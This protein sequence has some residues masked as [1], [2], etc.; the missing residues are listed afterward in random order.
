MRNIV[1]AIISILSF[2]SSAQFT[3]CGH[4]TMNGEKVAGAHVKLLD[5]QDAVLTNKQGGFCFTNVTSGKQIIYAEFENE[6]SILLPVLVNENRSDIHLEIIPSTELEGV[7]IIG[8]S[9]VDRRKEHSIKTEV[10][11]LEAHQLSSVSVEQLMDRTAGVKVR[12]SSGLGADSDV[13]IGG[14]NGKSVK[15]LVDGIPINYLGTSMSV[16]KMPTNMAGYIEVYKG[17]LPTEIGIDAL[18]AAVNIVTKQANKTNS[19]VSYQIGSFNT[20]RL[21]ANVFI[22]NSEKISF[23]ISAFANYSDNNFKIK[24]LPYDNLETG[25]TEYITSRLF[26]N[27]YQQINGEAFVNFE[28]RKWADLFK[29]TFNSFALSREMQSD[30]ASRNRPYGEVSVREYAYVVPSIRYEKT[31][32]DRKLQVSQ[33]LVYS[34]IINEFIDTLSNAYYDWK[35]EKHV[36]VGGSETGMDLSKLADPI[37]KTAT[38]NIT[39]RGLFTYRLSNNQKLVL[40]ITDT[41]IY[42]VADNLNEHNSK[43]NINYNRL[44]G[45]LGYQYNLFSNRMEGLTQA[46]YLISHSNGLLGDI[47]EDAD[48]RRQNSGFSIAQSLKWQTYNGWIFRASA[49]NTYRLPDQSEIFGDNIFIQ[50]N[51]SLKPERSFNVNAGIAYSLK[52]YFKVELNSYYRNIKDMI[53]L[54][55]L[56]QFQANYQNIDNVS[57]FGFEIDAIVTPIDNLD[58]SGN[59]TYNGFRFRGSKDNLNQNEHF[60]DARVSNMPFYFGNANISYRFNKVF[61]QKDEL[62]IYWNY[63]YVHQYYLDFIEKQY[64]PDGFLGLFGKSKVHTDRVIPVQHI[65]SAGLIWSINLPEE[66]KFSVSFELNN[67]FDHDVYNHFKMQNAGRAF[68]TKISFNF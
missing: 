44:I 54:K 64:E 62:N 19:S 32:L 33:F 17:V 48:Q 66:R 50:P 23:G 49:E 53:R 61:T 28:K 68:Y 30:F 47:F 1:L 31:F 27:G 22:R 57:G 55:E 8:K 7:T 52:K 60:V 56:T 45:A 13:I 36:T 67:I 39:Y 2:S 24:D 59:L 9:E 5:Y 40:N 11:D 63:H 14:F 20:H 29:I 51:L 26:H 6:S 43:T 65:N 41:Y 37:V 12:N 58:V 3:I 25:K 21:T 46:K 42:R 38:N 15:F 16:T 18:G 4:V 35:G 34:H 10:I